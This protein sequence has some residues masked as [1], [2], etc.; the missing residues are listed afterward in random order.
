MKTGKLRVLV[1]GSTFG[2]F[3]LE[4]LKLQPDLFEIAGLLAKGSARSVQCAEHYAIPLYTEIEQI[5]D[6]IDLA[7]VVLRSAV[8]GG[9]GTEISLQLLE[10]GIHV[11]QEQPVHYR[12]MTECLRTA[13]R[14]GLVFQIGDLY[15]HLP[16]VRQ[17]IA[18]AKTVLARQQGLFIDAAFASQVS[19]PMAHLLS[20]A[21]PFIRPWT[22]DTAVRNRGP[23]HL[24]TGMVGNIPIV[25]RIHNEVDPSEPDNYLHLLH[26]LTIGSEGGSLSLTDTHGPV[27]WHP[28]LHVP[29]DM[30][31]I[32]N[33]EVAGPEHL[34]ER[35]T[36]PLGQANSATYMDILTKQWPRAIADDLLMTRE[37]I[38]GDGSKDIRAQQELLCAT[39]W[40]EMTSALG[41][42]EL[43]AGRGHQPIP[44]TVL[45]SAA[46]N[47]GRL[48]Q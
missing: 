38:L 7:C 28:R 30:H 33:L 44:V 12:D 41:Y 1:C 48:R 17:F 42:P 9:K 29:M 35:S 21:L 23:F 37:N 39:Y 4:A 31:L 45:R 19:Y 5:P 22:F 3:Y 24:L 18:C 47:E 13:R 16:A 14:K 32:A 20:L 11:L 25:M 10:R 26:R 15:V 34:L 36:E 43:R 2:Q 46:S 8:M 27:V 6:D 40:Q